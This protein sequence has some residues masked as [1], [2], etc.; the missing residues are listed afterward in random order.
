[1]TGQHG[2]AVAS[3]ITAGDLVRVLHTKVFFGHQSVGM[4]ML[5]GVRG[6]YTAHG[7]AAPPIG[8]GSAGPGSDDGFIGHAFIGDNGKP[9][10]KIEDFAGKLRA[11]TGRRVG[12]AMMKFCYVDITSG[13]DV[14]AV[15]GSY[16]ATMAALAREF[17]DVTFIHATVPLTTQPGLLST[18]K[19]LLTGGGAGA[20]DNAARER[21]NALIRH[22]YAGD[23]LFD[24]AA[25]EST[26]PSGSRVT[27][28]GDG[29]RYYTLY[30]GYAA[31]SGHLNDEG[32]QVVATAW[33]RAIA[34]A[35]PR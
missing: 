34:Q 33:L 12:V 27:G 30:S 4:N 10:L 14:T 28:T 24:L 35:S 21:L 6:V 23:H 17:P 16:R 3:G 22:D 5:D 8:Q 9:L 2:V 19:S 20:A 1:M 11:G 32:A 31:D 13:T 29:Q 18:V 26:A 7:M 25:I 15:F